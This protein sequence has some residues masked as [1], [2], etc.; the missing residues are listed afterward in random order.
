[1][2]SRKAI[3]GTALTTM[4]VLCAIWGTQQVVI[5]LAEP[6]MSSLLQVGLRSAVAAVLMFII[7]LVR[8]QYR[9][10]NGSTWRPGLVVG[11]LFGLEF[12]LFAAGLQFTSASHISIFLYTAPIFA[13]LGLHLTLPEERLAPVQWLGIIVATAGI[14]LTFAGRGDA[15]AGDRAWIGDC[16]G[17]A[18]GGAW[19]ATTL[20]VRTSR[21][22]S[23][24]PAVTLWY[25]L[26]CGG[27]MATATAVALGQTTFTLSSTLVASLAYQTVVIS[28]ASYL[29]WFTLMRRYLASRLGVLTLLTPVFGIAF[30]VAVLGDRLTAPFILGTLVI[31]A[32]IIM[33][34]GR[35]LLVRRT[36]PGSAVV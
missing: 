36:S 3:D 16:L 34:N 10:L 9:E 26:A 5:K 30:S 22:T 27:V 24:P 2:N 19:G 17:I 8:G 14:V 25:Q 29:A 35:D 13:A 1:M 12:I 32:G 11:M 18:A 7:I 4:V 31:L 6:F 33:V 15:P 20:V 23:T 21:L 28:V